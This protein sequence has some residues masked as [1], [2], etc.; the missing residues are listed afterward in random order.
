MPNKE[1][2]GQIVLMQIGIS[3]NTGQRAGMP[4]MQAV[5]GRIGKVPLPASTVEVA[6]CQRSTHL[7]LR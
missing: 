5:R 1:I 2:V 7:D 3:L 6:S 4:S